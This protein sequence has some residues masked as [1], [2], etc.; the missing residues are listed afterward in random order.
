MNGTVHACK[1]DRTA[2]AKNSR[3]FFIEIIIADLDSPFTKSSNLA[4]SKIDN[5]LPYDNRKRYSSIYIFNNT[6]PEVGRIS[7]NRG[8]HVSQDVRSG[9]VVCRIL[10][11]VALTLPE[12]GEVLRC[13]DSWQVSRF[14]YGSL[15]K[16]RQ[17]NLLVIYVP[18]SS[19]IVVIRI[20]S[21]AN[22]RPDYNPRMNNTDRVNLTSIEIVSYLRVVEATVDENKC[23]EGG[24]N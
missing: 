16:T 17:S 3:R 12:V 14:A 6:H 9:I 18:I 8:G 13:A 5:F 21:S 15:N 7:S 11:R 24:R 10:E 19:I 2:R 1:C 20:H 22:V 23:S 4:E